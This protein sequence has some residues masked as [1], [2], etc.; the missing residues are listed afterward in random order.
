MKHYEL[1]FLDKLDRAALTRTCF[2]Q[3]DFT[4][5]EDAKALTDRHSKIEVWQGKQKVAFIRGRDYALAANRP[6]LLSILCPLI[7]KSFG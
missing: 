2:S 3:D 1:R 5:L 7:G 6:D 4:A